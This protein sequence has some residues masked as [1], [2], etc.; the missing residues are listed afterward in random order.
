M[1]RYTESCPFWNVPACID[2]VVGYRKL[3]IDSPRAGGRFMIDEDVLSDLTS[4]TKVKIRIKF[5]RWLSLQNRVEEYVEIPEAHIAALERL[6]DR[7]VTERLEDA[8]VWLS[9]KQLSISS[10][11]ELVGVNHGLKSDNPKTFTLKQFAAA[12][13]SETIDDAEAVVEFLV[14]QGLLQ[15]ASSYRDVR[16][17]PEG[18]QQV[19]SL[20]QNIADGSQVFVAMWFS[21]SLEN[22]Y[23]DGIALAIQDAGY[24]PVRI[25]RKEHN[26][27][28]DDE[29]IAEIR[30]SKFIVADF[31]SEVVD[32][33]LDDGKHYKDTL[34]RGGVYFE[35]GFAKGLGKEVIWTVQEDVLPFVH[36]DTRQFAH[37][38]WKDAADL[39]QKLSRRIS[40]TLGDGPKR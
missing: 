31:T 30:R 10:F 8:I 16:L 32:R 1:S 40:A 36:F 33:Q 22:A 39:R 15:R 35:A 13:S 21:K 2:Q 6:P 23:S 7:A 12:S 24:D 17:T 9:K 20:Q 34:A 25:D 28:I 27:K 19:Q 26:N 14:Q 37:I 29:I 18:W 4:S 5:S 3:C 38:V 11:V